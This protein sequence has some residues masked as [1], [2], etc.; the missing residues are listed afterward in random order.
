MDKEFNIRDFLDTSVLTEQQIN[1]CEFWVT[2]NRLVRNSGK[3]NFEEQRIPVNTSWDLDRLEV[4]LQNYQDKLL[5]EFL[6]YGW[7]L[8]AYNTTILEE[9]PRNQKGVEEFPDQVQEYIDK[10]L[11]QGSI[12][13]PFHTNPFGKVAR[14]LPLDTRAKQDSEER[15]VILN[16]L[17]PFEAGSVNESI[18][19]DKYAGLEDM[20]LRY[21]SVDSLAQIVR[22]K[23]RKARI[24][25]R[26]L[27][28][29]YRQLWMCPRS[30]HWLGWSFNNRLY[31]DV[32]LSMGSKSA[33]YCCQKTM[34]AIVHI[35]SNHGYDACN[36]LDDLGAANED[37]QA[38]KAYDCLGWILDTI[39]IKESTRKAK[40][41]SIH[42]NFPRHPL[43]Y[44]Y[45]DVTNYARQA[46]RN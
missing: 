14:F 24:F 34:S 44:R 42:C 21:P 15:R 40:P 32:T 18:S 22:R 31:F 11:Q 25:V 39:G 35:F 33:A 13:G 3:F 6:H 10:E 26:D 19:K 12:I 20:Q 38:D 2:A 17:Y 30:I 45:H 27:W 1:R 29:A 46:G 8:N 7:P 9:I 41:T 4:W 5:M 16:L 36:Y 28:K 37:D 43:Q 23:G